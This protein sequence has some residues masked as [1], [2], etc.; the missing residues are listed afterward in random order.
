MARCFDVCN[1]DAD[2]LCAVVQWRLED[3]RPAELVTGLKR[4]L[5]LLARVDA[6]AGDE[7]N[8]FDLSMQRNRADLLRLL[9]RGVHVR[10]FDHHASGGLPSHPC[11]ESHVDEASDACTSL[12]VDA[13][14]GGAHRAWALVGAYGDNLAAVADRLDFDGGVEPGDRAGLRRLGE[15]INYNAYGD[16]ERDVCIPPRL[17]YPLMARYADPRDMMAHES[18][19]EDIDAMRRSDLRQAARATL[20]WR[21]P[22]GSVYMLP[23]APWSRRVLGCF[24]NHLAAEA[25]G[26]AHAVLRPGGEGYVASVRAPLAHPHGAHALC[27]RF[28]GAGRARAA[29]I[30]SLG[31]GDLGRFIAAFASARWSSMPDGGACAAPGPP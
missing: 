4:D 3:T 16:D 22:A 10:Y 24:A 15:L 6:Q 31:A 30:D 18:I 28:G 20:L 21:G 14:L 9:T 27:R 5:A 25:P 19:V 2:G 11:L 29:G 23:D 26:L 8:V 17:L 7:V 1:G 13:H 12:L